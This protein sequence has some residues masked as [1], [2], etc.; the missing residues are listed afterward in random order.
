VAPEASGPSEPEPPP[1]PF[2]LRDFHRELSA[3]MKDLGVDR[4]VAAAVRRIR[5]QGVPREH[6]AKEFA[7]VLTRA[8]EENRGPVRRSAFAF[9][10]GLAAASDSPFDRKECMAGVEIFFKEVYDDLCEEVPRLNIIASAELLP[11][12]QS[13]L[14]EAQLRALLPKE[15]ASQTK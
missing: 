7:D 4:N 10:A 3:V 8:A 14:P 1:K 13:V 9:A 11:T 12:L 5:A 6:Q 15:V 2:N